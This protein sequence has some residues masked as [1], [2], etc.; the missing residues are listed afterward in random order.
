MRDAILHMRRTHPGWRPDTLLAEF[1]VD[2]RWTDQPL[3]SRARVA[4]LLKSAKLTRR[5]RQWLHTA[6][7]LRVTGMVQQEDGVMSVLAW[8]IAPVAIG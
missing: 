2:P 5:Y 7:I 8:R 3:P 1:R 6:G 4:A